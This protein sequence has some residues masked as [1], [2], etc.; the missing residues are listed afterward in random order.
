MRKY[1][2]FVTLGP[3]LFLSLQIRTLMHGFIDMF[4]ERGWREGWGPPG[5]VS[6]ERVLLRA[7]VTILLALAPQNNVLLLLSLSLKPASSIIKTNSGNYSTI[8]PSF[9]HVSDT[10]FCV[11]WVKLMANPFGKSKTNHELANSTTTTSQF[12]SGERYISCI[13]FSSI[14]H[15]YQNEEP[16]AHHINTGISSSHGDTITIFFPT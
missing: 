14:S 5:W 2:H 16:W 10:E 6:K 7:L 15:L 1:L 3:N 11:A 13:F 12:I 8:P 9:L 4:G